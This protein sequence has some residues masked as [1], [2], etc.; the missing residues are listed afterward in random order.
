MKIDRVTEYVTN[1]LLDLEN[2]RFGFLEVKT[3]EEALSVLAEQANL[4]ELWDSISSQ[5]WLQ[6]EPMVCIPSENDVGKFVVIEGNRRLAA[7]KT[8][9]DPSIL[10]TRL[11]KRVP[12]LSAE[13]KTSLQSIEITVVPDRRSADAYVGFKH[14]NGPSSWGSLP[15]AKFAADMFRRYATAGDPPETALKRVTDALGDTSA[16]MLRMLVAYEVLQQA[17]ELEILDRQLAEGKNFDFS[18]LYTMLPTPASRA[19]I[20]LSEAP[21]VAASIKKNP[22]PNSHIRQL[23]LMIGWLFGTDE[24]E[25][26]IQSQGQ[27]RPKLQKVLANQAATETL[28]STNNLTHASIKAGLDVEAWRNQ[29]IKAESSA[30][31]LLNDLSE[32]QHRMNDDEKSDSIDRASTLKSRYNTIIVLLKSIDDDN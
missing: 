11:Q 16:S 25:R 29:L 22:V 13:S 8:L 27:D 21:L 15:K 26:V 12:K 17:I 10:D 7:L 30:Q 14:V 18:H 28:I 2:P 4:K 5:G 1:L 6:L 23:S 20:G 31:Q 3:E 24:V 32:I 19:F 9:L